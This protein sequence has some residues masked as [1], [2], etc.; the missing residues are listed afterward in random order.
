MSVCLSVCHVNSI[1]RLAY[2]SY[3]HTFF[4]QKRSH[5]T[6]WGTGGF[7]THATGMLFG[8]STRVTGYLVIYYY[9]MKEA[10]LE[11]KS[12]I[13]YVMCSHE[14]LP[15]AC[16]VKKEKVECEKIVCE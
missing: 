15:C 13:K 10:L 12:V 2:F 3:W 9:Y 4:L 14:R 5:F 16:A 1:I 11:S 8:D 7:F 6:G